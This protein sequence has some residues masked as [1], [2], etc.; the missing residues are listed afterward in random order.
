MKR[1][2]LKVGFSCN[3]NC[4]FCVQAHKRNLGDRTTEELKGEMDGGRG[5]GCEGIVFT[6][7]EPTIRKDI[8]E[9]VKYAKGIGY[10]VIQ[11]QSN[12]RMFSYMDFVKKL[13]R[14]GVNEFSPAL[15]GHIPEIHDYLTRSAGA[16]DQV[17][18]G[19]RNL[20]ELDQYILTNSVINKFNYK[21]LPELAQLFVS[22]KVNQF[23]L[24]F[25]HA[26]GNALENFDS[27]VPRKSDV[28]P[29]VHRALDIGIWAGKDVMVEAYPFC[30]MR[31]YEKYC[32]ERFMPSTEIRY[33]D[34]FVE[35]FE[36]ERKKSG[37]KKFPQ[38]KLCKFDLI[39]EG[40]WKEYP[41]KFG[42]SEFKPVL[43]KKIKN[44]LEMLKTPPAKKRVYVF[45][46]GCI[47]SS[48]EG[49]KIE[50]FF[51]KNGWGISKDHR[52]SELIVF[53]ACG[54]TGLKIKE[55][56]KI[57]KKLKKEKKAGAEMVATGCLPKINKEAMRPV[58]GGKIIDITEFGKTFNSKIEIDNLH[59]SDCL[60]G[61]LGLAKHD[62]YH[63]IPSMGCLV[64][65]SYCAI[66]KAR[67][68]VRSKPVNEIVKEFRKAIKC[69]YKKITLMCDD[70]GAYGMDI[71]TNFIELLKAIISS[72]S[73]DLEYGLFLCRI[74]ARWLINY[75]EEF[76]KLLKTNKIISV[77][78]PIQSGSD[79]ILKLM[80]RGYAI[81]EVKKCLRKLKREFSS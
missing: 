2:D 32:A 19:I 52:D 65:C 20:R 47:P 60:V 50:S 62:V 71:S 68:S 17:V 35:D 12:G 66:K 29:Y 51:I 33:S 3:N 5:T 74:N 25:I 64:K 6:G 43:G 18:Q 26:I 21:H 28:E 22:L 59:V 15:H 81:E 58:F 55:S 69:G 27:M 14:A 38:C 9:L 8:I 73:Q 31:G 39:C 37:K 13:I 36:R 56:V 41:E 53:N 45:S 44:L 54:Y 7:G 11:L 76:K 77:H 46:N 79:R 10:R 16:Y 57:L 42:D 30:F 1:L 75:F 4:R 48:L 63:I 72:E 34:L 67:V 23:Q 80:A 61:E 49:K 24:A 40:P 78:I 70:L